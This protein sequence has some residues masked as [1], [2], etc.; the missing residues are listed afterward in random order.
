MYQQIAWSVTLFVVFLVALAFAFVYGES[1]RRKDYGPIQEKGYKIRK[2]Y[3]L[4]ILAAMAVISGITLT[5]LPYHQPHGVKAE[6]IK[7]VDV[8]AIQFGWEMSQTE[9]IVGEPIEFR[10]TSKD[11]THGF[12]L[13]DENMQLIAQTQ[14]MPEYI[15]SVFYTFEKPGKYKILCMEYCSVGHH[16]MIREINVKDHQGGH[17]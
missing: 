12:G 7:V 11:V 17:E 13:Y 15:N 4:G 10:V 14:A 3:F 5:R 2:Y 16:I 6:E 8:N 1:R 9:F